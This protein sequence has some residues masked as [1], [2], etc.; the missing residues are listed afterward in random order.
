LRCLQQ[1][2]LFITF[3]NIGKVPESFLGAAV[4]LLPMEEC[5]EARG[6]EGT[7][8]AGPLAV[9]HHHVGGVDQQPRLDGGADHEQ[10]IQGW[11]REAW[12]AV[13]HHLYY[14]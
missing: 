14:I 8:A 2:I 7:A 13:L 6:E 1:F 12:E 5:E 11:A 9:E 3:L 4:E 10:H